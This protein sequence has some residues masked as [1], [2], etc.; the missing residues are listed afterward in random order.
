MRICIAGL[1]EHDEAMPGTCTPERENIKRELNDEKYREDVFKS[2]IDVVKCAFIK[3]WE[4]CLGK[5]EE[6]VQNNQ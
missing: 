4:L 5:V 1:T 3:G 2:V 6:E